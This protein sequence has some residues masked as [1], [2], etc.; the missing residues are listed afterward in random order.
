M[1]RLSALVCCLMMLAMPVLAEGQRGAFVLRPSDGSQPVRMYLRSYALVIGNDAYRA[2]WPRLS[3]AVADARAVAAELE[4][5]ARRNQETSDS[6]PWPVILFLIFWCVM[7]FGGIGMA[8]FA[9]LA[10][11]YGRKLG[12]GRYEWHGIEVST[13]SSSGRRSSGGSSWSSGGGGFSG[14]GGSSGGGGAS[15]SW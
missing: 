2:G 12:K 4:A 10:T 3:N 14:G 7:F 8:L 11:K 15:G 13:S 5:R 6:L 1:R 9:A